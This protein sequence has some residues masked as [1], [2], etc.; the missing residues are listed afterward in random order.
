MLAALAWRN[1]WRQP[2]RTILSLGSIGLSGAITIFV[3]S[4]Q[5]GTY[6]TIKENALRLIDGFAQIQAPGYA[7]DPD[8][9]KSVQDPQG[10]V[11]HLKAVPGITA[12]P[13]AASFAILSSGE[14]SYGAQVLGVDPAHDGAVSSISNTIKQG[15]A[16]RAGDNDAVIIG[17]GLARDLKLGLGG[18]LTMLGSGRDGS[19][20]A[21]ALT[22]V[23]TFASGVNELD[24]QLVEIP[25][26]RFQS[27]FAME[28][29]VSMIVLSA[30]H[31]G[32]VDRNLPA[33]RA[34]A[35]KQ[36]LV[37][38]SWSQLEPALHDAIL[39]DM[40]ISLLLYV[41]LIVITVFIILNTLLMSVLERTREFGMLMAIGMRPGQI[42]RMVWLELLF[43]SAA[44]AACSIVLGGAITAW[45]AHQ[46]IAFNEANVLFAQWGMPAV[47]HP[48]LNQVSAFAGPL[49]I[50][51]AIAIA[52]LVPYM[53]V[54]HLAPVAAMRAE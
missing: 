36:G 28:G 10:L 47:L 12:V 27:D 22:V 13:R 18:K 51:F 45:F 43:L 30:A 50:A 15:R 37:V 20:A 42:G 8:L 11:A 23:G 26:V 39:L 32:I 41:S 4:L 29:R 9:R 54:L 35:R 48:L 16:L 34:I 7:D 44:G 38:R 14:R 49:A 52:G 33:L 46:G 5:L 17:A 2:R 53:R 1:I 21:D 31:L 25:L 24:R 3:L 6:A 40:S 19:L